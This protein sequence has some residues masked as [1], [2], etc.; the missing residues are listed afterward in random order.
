MIDTRVRIVRVLRRNSAAQMRCRY[1]M[2]AS[3]YRDTGSN[4]G[5]QSVIP[6]KA[7]IQHFHTDATSRISEYK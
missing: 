6:A 5:F 7:G 1:F 4:V 3:Q 2:I